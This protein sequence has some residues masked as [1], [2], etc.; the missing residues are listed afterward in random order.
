MVLF[1]IQVPI[2]LC[3]HC[4]NKYVSVRYMYVAVLGVA[5]DSI[6]LEQP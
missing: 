5:T 6:Q 3:L 1:K 2:V 4:K